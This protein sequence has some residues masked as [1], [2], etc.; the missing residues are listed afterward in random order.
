MNRTFSG[1]SVPP[2]MTFAFLKGKVLVGQ[3]LILVKVNE[4]TGKE[5]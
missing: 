4:A 1:R 3:K 2:T 5:I